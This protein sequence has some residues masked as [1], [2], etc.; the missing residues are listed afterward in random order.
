MWLPYSAGHQVLH[1]LI[2]SEGG[3]LEAEVALYLPIFGCCVD[4][5]ANFDKFSLIGVFDNLCLNSARYIHVLK[6]K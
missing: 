3:E 6:N 5:T 4:A 2:R 1:P